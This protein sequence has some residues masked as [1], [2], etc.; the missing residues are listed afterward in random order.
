MYSFH[1]ESPMLLVKRLTRDVVSEAHNLST[2]PISVDYSKIT[3]LFR[4]AHKRAIYLDGKIS[5]T[6]AR[7]THLSQVT[8]SQNK[9]IYTVVNVL[10]SLKIINISKINKYAM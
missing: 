1:S 8:K 9:I 6:H 5:L 10:Y 7:R 4:F 3:S 2:T